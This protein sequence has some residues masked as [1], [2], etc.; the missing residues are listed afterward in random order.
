MP[1]RASAHGDV[2]LR[3]QPPPMRMGGWGARGL[4]KRAPTARGQWLQEPPPLPGA[5]ASPCARAWPP[6]CHALRLGQPDPPLPLG[7]GQPSPSLPC[8]CPLAARPLFRPARVRLLRGAP[9]PSAPPPLWRHTGGRTRQVA[10]AAPGMDV[11]R[12]LGGILPA[13]LPPGRRHCCRRPPLRPPACLHALSPILS[14]GG[15]MPPSPP[16]FLRPL[17]RAPSGGLG[18]PDLSLR[19]GG[20]PGAG[21]APRSRWSSRT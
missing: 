20:G 10:S 21:P 13:P 6:G 4:R 17:R 1:T 3:A 11:P 12:S 5:A 15:G 18:C 7:R 16:P 8:T 2:L 19:R 14:G 9:L